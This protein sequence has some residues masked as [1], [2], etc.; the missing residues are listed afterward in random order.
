MEGI[1]V[2]Q[3]GKL[4]SFDYKLTNMNHIGNIRSGKGTCCTRLLSPYIPGVLSTIISLEQWLD[5]V[6][7]K[8]IQPRLKMH[9]CQRPN[10]GHLS[11]DSS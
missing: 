8:I 3:R 1:L 10:F 7:H 5:L 9:N 6:N 2:A 11:R 4:I